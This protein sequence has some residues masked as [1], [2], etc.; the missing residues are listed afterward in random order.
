M[1]DISPSVALRNKHPNL[2][3]TILLVAVS[4]LMIAAFM[5]LDSPRASISFTRITNIALVHMPIFWITFF[6]ISGIMCM[7]GALTTKYVVARIGLVLS[8][9]IG[10]FLALGYWLSYFSTHAV[11]ISAPVIW[12]FYALICIINSSE[13]SINPLSVALQQEIHKT[14]ATDEHKEDLKNGHHL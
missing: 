14:L 2:F 9:G 12:T 4:N 6:G 11:G 5:I 8:A 7:H 13:P 3:R 1:S 10:A